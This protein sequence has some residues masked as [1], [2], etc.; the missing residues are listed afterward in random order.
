[1]AS[2]MDSEPKVFDGNNKN[3]ISFLR[4]AEAVT[5]SLQ[6]KH[7]SGKNKK[8][9]DVL[10]ILLFGIHI[11]CIPP[12]TTAFDDVD[13]EELIDSTENAGAAVPSRTKIVLRTMFAELRTE[14]LFHSAQTM[15]LEAI[16][17]LL[18]PRLPEVLTFEIN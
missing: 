5:G 8:S 4:Q 6:L 7:G 1:M 13:I 12:Q 14:Q 10:G 16:L 18:G 11:A 3:C 2:T 9:Y 15:L 17:K